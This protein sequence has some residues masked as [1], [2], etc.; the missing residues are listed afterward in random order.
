[1]TMT[2]RPRTRLIP[3]R[4]PGSSIGMYTGTVRHRRL[5]A[6]ERASAREFAPKLFLAYLDVDALPASL[7]PVPL[8]SARRTAPVRFSPVSYTQIR[9]NQTDSYRV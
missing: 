7:D 4:G 5:G 3:T 8:W 9:P 1:M 6:H 2:V